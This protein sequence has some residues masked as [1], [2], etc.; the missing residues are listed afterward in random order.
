MR[1]LNDAD[2]NIT[3]ATEKQGQPLDPGPFQTKGVLEVAKTILATLI[4][5]IEPLHS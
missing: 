3:R 4:T 5:P 1:Y 2:P